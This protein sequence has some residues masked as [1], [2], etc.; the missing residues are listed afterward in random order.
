MHIQIHCGCTAAADNVESMV[1]SRY[2]QLSHSDHWPFESCYQTYWSL[3]NWH[4][5]QF[6]DVQAVQD[7]NRLD[8]QRCLE[9]A[10]VHLNKTMR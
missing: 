7:I 1:I 10:F 6:E 8:I 2:L 9:C 4:F 5:R 3:K